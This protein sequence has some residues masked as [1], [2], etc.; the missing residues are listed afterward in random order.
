[1]DGRALSEALIGG[2]ASAANTKTI[3]ASRDFERG[4]WRQYLK[5]SQVD[6]TVYLDEGNRCIARSK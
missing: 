6:S 1:M 5:I 2:Q 3:V 4:R